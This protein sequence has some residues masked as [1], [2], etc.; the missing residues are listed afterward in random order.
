MTKDE[1]EVAKLKLEIEQ[2][3][4]SWWKK[5]P[6]V[7][8]ISTIV[9]AILGLYLTVFSDF[10]KQLKVQ[11][12]DLKN[13]NEVLVEQIS[14]FQGKFTLLE[15][16]NEKMEIKSSKLKDQIKSYGKCY[17]DLVDEIN[18]LRNSVLNVEAFRNAIDRYGADF[19]I[20][21]ASASSELAKSEVYDTL[22]E[23]L[24]SLAQMK[25]ALKTAPELEL[26]LK[27]CVPESNDDMSE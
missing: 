5:P 17:S 11:H 19:D 8:A 24:G 20:N 26:K 10:V 23:L 7:T 22:D 15:T 25:V 16:Q 1:A 9:I 14:D 6:Y 13:K 3:S 4:L 27:E 21:S 18:V 2:L 12:E